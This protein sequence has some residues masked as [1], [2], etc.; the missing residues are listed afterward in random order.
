MEMNKDTR[1]RIFAAADTLFEQAGRAGFPTVDAVRKAAKVSMG[2]A[3]TAMKEWRRAQTA[4]AAPVAIQVPD[5][6]Q[7]LHS[8]ALAVLWQQAQE[9]ANESLRAAQAGWEAERVESDILNKQLSDAYEAQAAELEIAQAKIAEIEGQR[10][11]AS[12]RAV[13]IAGQLDD[14]RRALADAKAA[15]ERADARTVEIER[16]ATDLRAELDHAHRDV[17]QVRAELS[18]AKTRAEQGAATLAD[19]REAGAALAETLRAQLATVTAQ[20]EAAQGTYQEQR[21]AFAAMESELGLARKEAGQ[22]REDAATLRGQVD[23][24][25][26]QQTAMLDVFKAAAKDGEQGLDKA[27]K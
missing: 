1:D 2:D 4:Q 23:A 18:A 12:N 27:K 25:K 11:E 15:A 5:A 10:V 24:M 26:D 9:M 16:R 14:T 21:K 19:T 13:E 3:S 17:S 6:V 7:Q 22:A 8:Q 20:A